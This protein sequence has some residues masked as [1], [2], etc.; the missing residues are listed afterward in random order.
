MKK[1]LAVM[2]ALLLAAICLVGCTRHSTRGQYSVIGYNENS[3]DGYW[4]ASYEKFDGYKERDITITGEG[5]HTFTVEIVTNSGLLGLSI[6]DSE[7]TSLYSGNEIPSSS[8]EVE[9]DSEGKYSV[10]FDAD[11]H[12]GSFNIKWE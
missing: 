10:R 9:A 2:L 5:S 4:E 3:G 11:N 6:E 7:G 1:I 8:F 12:E